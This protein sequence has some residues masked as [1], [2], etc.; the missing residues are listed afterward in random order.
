MYYEVI[1]F[2]D[3]QEEKEVK[4]F[5]NE[6]EALNCIFDLYKNEYIT[7]NNFCMHSTIKY[8]FGFRKCIR[9]NDTVFKT[10]TKH[11]SYE[12]LIDIF[13]WSDDYTS[14]YWNYKQC[15]L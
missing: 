7:R 3:Y 13:N 11:L 6:E 14:S 8:M 10:E 9:I 12:E 15:L 1:T 2:N 4:T 5:T